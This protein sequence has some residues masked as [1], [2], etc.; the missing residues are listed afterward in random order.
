MAKEGCC[1]LKGFLTFLVLKL[2]AQKER[3]GEEIRQE[4]EKRRGTRPSP[5]TI[6]PVLKHLVRSGLI[7]ETPCEGKEKRYRVTALG[8]REAKSATEQFTRM[9]AGLM[10]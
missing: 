10:D 4:I 8:R 5:G 3:C 1:E 7:E 2:I 9:F 6:Y